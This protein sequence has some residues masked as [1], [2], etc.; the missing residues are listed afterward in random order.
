MN[1]LRSIF[2]LSEED[3]GMGRI[4]IADRI[5]PQ[6]SAGDMQSWDLVLFGDRF[7]PL[8]SD[9]FSFHGDFLPGGLHQIVLNFLDP[10]GLA[11]SSP[12]TANHDASGFHTII[13]RG[14]LSRAG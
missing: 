9:P 12:W 1:A 5:I 3:K 8:T 14:G 10:A 7:E 13:D 4:A 11:S 2:E 6:T